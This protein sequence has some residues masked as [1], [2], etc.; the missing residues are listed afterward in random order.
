LQTRF[1]K[2]GRAI[3]PEKS[4]TVKI[5]QDNLF[6]R[7]LNIYLKLPENFFFMQLRSGSPEMALIPYSG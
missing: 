7:R 3:A 1:F 5:D 4:G 6:R 2:Q